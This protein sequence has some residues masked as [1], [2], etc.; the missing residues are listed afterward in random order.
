VY[1]TGVIAAI[2]VAI[3]LSA[4]AIV[5]AGPAQEILGDLA[6]SEGSS[7]MIAGVATVAV[8]V[9][10]GVGSAA[11]L[12][13]TDYGIYGIVAG[14]LIAA[15]G[16]VMLVVPSEAER[17]YAAA[18]DSEED[19]A[20]ALENLA[21]KARMARIVSGIVN[22]SAGVA[23]LLFPINLITRY[24]YVYSAV[25]S[26]GAAAIDFLLPS[27]EERAYSR[28]LDAVESEEGSGGSD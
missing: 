3:V 24:D 27:T 8:G 4:A 1:R 5:V 19:C 18:K 23:S 12:M 7:R 21:E 15:P 20:L 22:A 10:V 11:F 2:V 16:V 25:S 17:A 6:R 14:G 13:G 28:Y 26:F 9:A